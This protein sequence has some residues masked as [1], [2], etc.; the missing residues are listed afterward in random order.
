MLMYGQKFLNGFA[1]PEVAA[2]D[3][4]APVAPAAPGGLP[5]LPGQDAAVP[6]PITPGAPEVTPW[7]N[8]RPPETAAQ[9]DARFGPIT[10]PAVEAYAAANNMDWDTA[11]AT[12]EAANVPSATADPAAMMAAQNAAA[13]TQTMAAP[14]RLAPDGTPYASTADVA[15]VMGRDEALK[16]MGATG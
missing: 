7:Q 16:A 15:R 12:M 6:P 3:G 11:R 4:A 2:P 13:H 14:V 9:S 10:D 8:P 5:A 1:G